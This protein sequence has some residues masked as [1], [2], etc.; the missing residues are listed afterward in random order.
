M[1]FRTNFRGS[2]TPLVDSV[3]E[4]LPPQFW[5]QARYFRG[6]AHFATHVTMDPKS[7]RERFPSELR[8]RTRSQATFWALMGRPRITKACPKRPRSVREA[9]QRRSKEAP[10]R[11]WSVPG[12]LG[13]LLG[14]PWNMPGDATGTPLVPE[15]A[16]GAPREQFWLYF[17]CPGKV[18]ELIWG[19]YRN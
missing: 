7:L 18:A 14:V 12:C 11:P 10:G 19:R 4:E 1:P 13:K 5:R 17:G 6:F 8:K 16:S 9:S 2:S 3:R 15:A